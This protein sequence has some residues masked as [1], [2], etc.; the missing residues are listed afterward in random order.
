MKDS[1]LRR[2]LS[3]AAL[4]ILLPLALVAQ[5]SGYPPYSPP[6]GSDPMVRTLERRILQLE[7]RIDLL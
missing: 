7:Q 2:V 6:P 1:T 3:F 4:P 5:Q